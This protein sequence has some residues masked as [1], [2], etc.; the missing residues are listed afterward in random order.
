MKNQI[1]FKG[2]LALMAMSLIFLSS[3]KK[4]EITHKKAISQSENQEV[5]MPDYKFSA[6]AKIPG[7]NA[8]NGFL[9]VKV[10]SDNEADLKEYVSKLE[11]TKVVFVESDPNKPEEVSPLFDDASPV[12]LHFDW[13]HFNK[14]LEKGKV[15]AMYMQSA[16]EKSLINVSTFSNVTSFTTTSGYACVNL[17]CTTS[18]AAN[19]LCRPIINWAF[20]N[21]SGI[22]F[23]NDWLVYSDNLELRTFVGSSLESLWRFDVGSTTIFYQ[24]RLN[25]SGRLIT[26]TLTDYNGIFA[27]ANNQPAQGKATATFYIAG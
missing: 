24:P 27:A 26:G 5:K 15:Y 20:Y 18:V 10:S 12:N 11:K 22:S 21:Q 1:T 13:T 17:Y 19:C 16:D 8:K 4:E 6:V 7:E 3:C 9:S 25:F 14:N 2:G 23:Y